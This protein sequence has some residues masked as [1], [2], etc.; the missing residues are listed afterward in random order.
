M[1]LGALYA[2]I[3]QDS[4]EVLDPRS[5]VVH[6]PQLT[7]TDGVGSVLAPIEIRTTDPVLPITGAKISPSPELNGAGG[8]ILEVDY[9]DGSTR[10]WDVSPLGELEPRRYAYAFAM[11]VETDHE[12]SE[13]ERGAMIDGVDFQSLLGATPE[14]ASTPAPIPLNTGNYDEQPAGFGR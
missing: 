13:E 8:G 4:G 6:T 2:L 11:V 5:Y 10:T 3:D 12:L 7:V 1:D 14:Y 9:Q